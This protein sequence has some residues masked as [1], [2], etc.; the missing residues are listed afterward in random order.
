LGASIGAWSGQP[1]AAAGKLVVIRHG[2]MQQAG[3]VFHS[4][5]RRRNGAQFLKPSTHVG[6]AATS[7]FLTVAEIKY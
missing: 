5:D 6:K 7:V 4:L 3:R 2:P 1:T